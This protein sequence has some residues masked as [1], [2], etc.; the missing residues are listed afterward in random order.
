MTW[1]RQRRGEKENAVSRVKC[2]TRSAR[3]TNLNHVWLG[4][5]EGGRRLLHRLE[6]LHERMELVLGAQWHARKRLLHSPG[7][8]LEADSREGET[9][10]KV[11]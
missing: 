11:P 1:G 6:L 3:S 7:T 9:P 10:T 8:E 5:F 4:E 2:M